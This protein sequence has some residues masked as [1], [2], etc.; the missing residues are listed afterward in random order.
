MVDNHSYVH[1]YKTVSIIMKKTLDV[2]PQ[3]DLFLTKLFILLAVLH[4][5]QKFPL[6]SSYYRTLPNKS[7]AAFSLRCSYLDAMHRRRRGLNIFQFTM[8]TP[9]K[10]SWI[11]NI[12]ELVTIIRIYDH[13]SIFSKWPFHFITILTPTVRLTAGFFFSNWCNANPN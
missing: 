11:S 7:I 4:F 8:K 9:S 1:V 12:R 5:A 2:D 6:L 3:L 10:L 13:A